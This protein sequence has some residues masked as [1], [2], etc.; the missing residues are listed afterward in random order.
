MKSIIAAL[1]LLH[2]CALF[3]QA[4]ANLPIDDPALFCIESTKDDASDP[5]IE[6]YN[7]DEIIITAFDF[8]EDGANEVMVAVPAHSRMYCGSSGF[9]YNWKVFKRATSGKWL[10]VGNLEMDDNAY[11]TRI[12]GKLFVLLHSRIWGNEYSLVFQCMHEGGLLSFVVNNL[13]TYNRKEGAPESDDDLF[14]VSIGFLKTELP[15]YTFSRSALVSGIER[16]DYD[17]L[18]NVKTTLRANV[19]RPFKN[20]RWDEFN[21][22]FTAAKKALLS[23]QNKKTIPF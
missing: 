2:A 5:S 1:L 13:T 9:Y 11:L 14:Y 21:A 12:K 19:S 23:R 17:D 6:R 20:K 18:L 10:C 3:A 8:D 4:G 16:V 7:W 15:I 22:K